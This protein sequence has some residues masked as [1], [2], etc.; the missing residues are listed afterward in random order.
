MITSN[1]RATGR[2]PRLGVGVEGDC[3]ASL[4]LSAKSPWRGLLGEFDLPD[5]RALEDL[6]S[7]AADWGNDPPK[8]IELIGAPAACLLPV[9]WL[10]TIWLGAEATINLTWPEVRAPGADQREQLAARLCAQVVNRLECANRAAAEAQWGVS[11]GPR[12]RIDLGAF[13]LALGLIDAWDIRQR[14]GPIT[15]PMEW[16]LRVRAAM[17][18]LRAR[19]KARVALYGAGT[20]TRALG[21]VLMSA[22]V[23][24]VCIVDDDENQHSERLWGFPI[25]S[26]RRAIDMGVQAV[27]L[28]ANVHEPKLWA[29]RADFERARVEVVRLYE[30]V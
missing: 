16:R 27:I 28:S 23:E 9:I 3:D 11:P 6:A 19:G 7:I 15:D 5:D 22:P 12:P 1:P 20:H 14:T 24:V 10:R 29:N 8:A 30:E 21:P 4:G 2:A 26:R 13:D 17:E 18:D 25:V